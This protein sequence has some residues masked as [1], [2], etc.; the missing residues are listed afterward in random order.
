[1]VS[2]RPD[3]RIIDDALW[4]EVQKQ[5]RER[6]NGGP[7][8]SGRVLSQRKSRYLLSGIVVCD[9]CGKPLTVYGVTGSTRVQV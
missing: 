7:Q 4:T 1:M 5:I 8:K 3:L 9:E 2:E 6:S